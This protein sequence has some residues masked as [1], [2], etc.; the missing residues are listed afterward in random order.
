[1]E[2]N[3]KRRQVV[4]LPRIKDQND[5][6]VNRHIKHQQT[7]EDRRFHNA[8]VLFVPG[9][10][11]AGEACGANNPDGCPEGQKCYKI[12]YDITI[13]RGGIAPDMTVHD[14]SVLNVIRT[15]KLKN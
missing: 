5:E 15:R 8:A 3:Q 13:T 9:R 2:N 14:N 4:N 11:F 12:R 10:R 7:Y 1:M 6:T